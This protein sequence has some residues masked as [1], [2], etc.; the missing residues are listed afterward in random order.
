MKNS[1]HSGLVNR[2]VCLRKIDQIFTLH[3]QEI[4]YR[5]QRELR[6][7]LKNEI[8][9]EVR[10]EYDSYAYIYLLVHLFGF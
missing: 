10:V 1:Y 2:I 7:I 4:R 9:F 8:G 3:L 6:L 5:Y